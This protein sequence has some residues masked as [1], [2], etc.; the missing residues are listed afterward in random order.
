[1]DIREI[2]DHFDL[3][4]PLSASTATNQLKK[5]SFTSMLSP[6]RRFSKDKLEKSLILQRFT[7]PRSHNITSFVTPLRAS[8]GRNGQIRLNSQL[9]G[10]DRDLQMYDPEGR[11]ILSRQSK[12]NRTLHRITNTSPTTS[13]VDR[14]K[15]GNY[16]NAI[17]TGGRTLGDD[18]PLQA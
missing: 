6:S 10:Y 13:F 5:V 1:M 9:N 16:T 2:S 18:S 17:Q 3:L 11:V 7:K 4:S 15:R 12:R 14:I 8:K